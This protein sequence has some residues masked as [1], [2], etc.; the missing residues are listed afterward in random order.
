MRMLLLLVCPVFTLYLFW[1]DVSDDPA[2][3]SNVLGSVFLGVGM[4][5]VAELIHSPLRLEFVGI[6]VGLHTTL[7]IAQAF[8]QSFFFSFVLRLI[9]G[10]SPIP[11]EYLWVCILSLLVGNKI[12]FG[13]KLISTTH[14]RTKEKMRVSLLQ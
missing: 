3:D 1:F 12:I 14:P 13:P 11:F 6:P 10:I 9:F 8:V 2:D 4:C 5:V 7:D